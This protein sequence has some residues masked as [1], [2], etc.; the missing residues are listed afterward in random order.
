MQETK[1][2][3]DLLL[4]ALAREIGR[5]DLLRLGVR[6]LQL[7]LSR[8]GAK[9]HVK[10]EPTGSRELPDQPRPR[11]AQVRFVRVWRI[12]AVLSSFKKSGCFLWDGAILVSCLRK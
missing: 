12:M 6:A 2:F 11:Y 10:F 1:R 3:P 5:D 4:T 7:F 8:F 9:V